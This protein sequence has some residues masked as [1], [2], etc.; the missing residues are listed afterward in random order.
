MKNLQPYTLIFL[1]CLFACSD[2]S[3]GTENN[4]RQMSATATATMSKDGEITTRD[5]TTKEERNIEEFHKKVWKVESDYP[6]IK[7]PS[8]NNLQNVKTIQN[9]G[10]IELE[11]GTLIQLA[12]CDCDK[13]ATYYLNRVFVELGYQLLF[14]E[15]GYRH[16]GRVFGY[17]W[18]VNLGSG[19][20][21]TNDGIPV[22][23]SMS[24]IN[25]AMILN[26][27]C[28]PIEQPFHKYFDRYLAYSKIRD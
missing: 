27:W 8:I 2:S 11:D 22:G 12:G 6:G 17:I 25:E 23:T 1:V 16:N 10:S 7:P 3:I 15:S 14:V 18:E 9:D 26:N 19:Q 4:T 24:R 20:G 13:Q 5:A 28:K 21:E